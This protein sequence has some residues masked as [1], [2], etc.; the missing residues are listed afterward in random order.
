MRYFKMGNYKRKGK[1][2]K[3]CECGEKFLGTGKYCPECIVNRIQKAKEKYY[4][5]RNET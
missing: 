2:Q 1:P 4:K 5:K 3:T